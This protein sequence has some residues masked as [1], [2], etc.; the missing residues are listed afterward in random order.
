[1]QA[2][3]ELGI[4]VGAKG[5]SLE[6][7]CSAN[8]SPDDPDSLRLATQGLVALRRERLTARILVA[9]FKR[10][11][12]VSWTGTEIAS[13]PRGYVKF[14]DQ[15]FTA[16]GFSFLRPLLRSKR[17]VRKPKPT[18]VLIDV[19]DERCDMS[20]MSSFRARAKKATCRGQNRLS[21]LGVVAS[22]SFDSEAWVEGRRWGF[23]VLNLQREFGDEALEAMALLERAYVGVRASSIEATSEEIAQLGSVLQ[24]LRVNP[25]VAD[26]RSIGF[27]VLTGLALRAQGWEGVMLSQDVAFGNTTRDVDVLG[28]REDDL[29]IVEC[30]AYHSGKE[31]AA[32]EVKKFY[33]ETV[34]ACRKWWTESHGAPKRCLAEIWTTGIVGQ[35]AREELERT[36]LDARVIPQMIEAAQ[37][38]SNLPTTIRG[39]ASGL[40]S[41]ISSGTG[42]D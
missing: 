12:L 18:P 5:S 23:L 11:N 37:I 1:M 29:R 35:E 38:E 26:L 27:E 6:F 16:Q 36:S 9:R 22:R 28:H 31:L 39:R 30:K 14:N 2:L 42:L 13:D 7:I 10:E 4:Q 15:A 19:V 33:T 24:D 25:V 8:R 34:P 20:T 17:G 32:G 3:A 41:S 40:L 21:Y